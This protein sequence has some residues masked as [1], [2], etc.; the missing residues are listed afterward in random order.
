MNVLIVNTSEKTGGAAIAANRLMEALISN[1]VKAKMLVRDKQTASLSVC[2]IPQS[3]ILKVKFAWERFVVWVHNRLSRQNL[4]QVD[5][6]N[7]GTD[8]TQLPEFKWADV[9][10]LHWVNQG[11]LSMRDIEKIVES[12]KRVVWTLHDQWPYTGVCHYTEQCDRYTTHCYDCPL[13]KGHSEND[14]SYRLFER[15]LALYQNINRITFVGCSQWITDLAKKSALMQAANE[16]T[17]VTGLRVVHIPNA[18][19]H[20]VFRPTDR[21]EARRVHGLPADKQL[22]LF[23]SLKVIDKRK[24]I[25]YLIEACR[26]LSAEHPELKE[27]I[28]IV[29]VGKQAES[30][31]GMF[32]FPLYSIP[33]VSEERKMALLYTAV[34]AFITPSLQ[35]NLPNTI[36][37]AMSVGTV[38]V[39][40]R[41]G[42]IP[43]MIHH[44]QDGYV[45][46]PCDAHDLADGI[47]YVLDHDNA[48]RLSVAAAKFAA[49]TYNPSRIARMH[50]AVYRNS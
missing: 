16:G 20:A 3:P 49:E 31:Q 10:H 27:C 47:R 5:I 33:Y 13:L 40:F 7:T 44:E 21:Q 43:E 14:L 41:V 19:N 9:I 50:E 38:C 45:A 46:N 6:A 24:G 17:R 11:F 4:W 15:K 8:I 2:A 36:V 28:G 29:V 32:P 35:D 39:G 18:I 22:L 26:L 42:G 30:M 12:G 25:D 37:E 34:D 48:E 1:G 23:S